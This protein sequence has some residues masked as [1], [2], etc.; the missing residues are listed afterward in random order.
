MAS[1]E[2]Q[3]KSA[4]TKQRAGDLA[5]AEKVLR[6]VLERSPGMPMASAILGYVLMDTN[7]TAEAIELLSPIAEREPHRPLVRRSLGMAL[8]RVG[9]SE[10]ALEHLEAA[11]LF[12][13]ADFEAMF[14][15]AATLERLDRLEQAE[16]GF[17][18]TIEAAAGNSQALAQLGERLARL[19]RFELAVGC[20]EQVIAG[21]ATGAPILIRLASCH[22]RLSHYDKALDAAKRAR[23]ADPKNAMACMV[24]ADIYE[25][26]HKLEKA[27]ASA[28]E[29]LELAPDQTVLARILARVERRMGHPERGEEI[30]RAALDKGVEDKRVLA[31]LLIE[32]GHA[33]DAMGEFDQAFEAIAS[34][35]RAWL[36]SLEG[37][38][39]LE[40]FPK[41]L[42]ER[43]VAAQQ[44][45]AVGEPQDW[46][47]V[48]FVGFPR[49]GTT[50]MEQVLRAHEDVESLDEINL[51]DRPVLRSARLMTG[52]ESED[53]VVAALSDEQAHALGKEYKAALSERLGQDST[54]R[55]VIDKLPLNLTR[56]GLIRRVFPNAKLLVALRDPRDCC[57]S[58]FMQSFDANEAMLHFHSIESTAQMYAGVMDLWL[59]SRDKIG[60]PFLEYRYEDLTA[61][62][63]PTVRRVLEFLGLDWNDGISSFQEG[64]KTRAI[65][66]PS[67]ERVVAPIDRKAVARWRNY[68]KHMGEAMRTLQP[69]VEAFGYSD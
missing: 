58:G 16:E 15:R 11:C 62:F 56:L 63:E 19:G 36:E 22:Q 32:R 65:S 5:G 25:K 38:F 13:P 68:E 61:E 20:Y 55:V 10:A 27:A 6:E 34:G 59:A 41:Q 33:L 37:Q 9:Q 66:T 30:T 3:I 48:F 52:L 47:P 50:L 39:D 67:Y 28:R 24:I 40:T 49:S 44:L 26:T 60:Q 4:V 17:Q 12:N 7:R 2:E 53:A 21:G 29:G 64:A 51:L 31:P 69:Y 18:E 8:N 14:W 54:K 43:Q 57:L 42:Q 23:N 1:L 35:K 46:S 45:G